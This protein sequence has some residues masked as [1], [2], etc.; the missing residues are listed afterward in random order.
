MGKIQAQHGRNMGPRSEPVNRRGTVTSIMGMKPRSPAQATATLIGT[1]VSGD[2]LE[3]QR[4]GT[5]S[6]FDFDS[7]QQ[8]SGPLTRQG[9]SK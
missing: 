6:Q 2:E 3:V 9:E 7:T 8:L 1:V 5:S 4:L